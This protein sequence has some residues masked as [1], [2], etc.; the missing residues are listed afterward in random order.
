MNTGQINRNMVP[1]ST[2]LCI[3]S[4]SGFLRPYWSNYEENEISTARRHVTMKDLK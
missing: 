2:L 1:E 4:D 3:A